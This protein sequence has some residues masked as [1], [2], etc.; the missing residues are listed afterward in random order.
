MSFQTTASQDISGIAVASLL[1]QTASTVSLQ[2]SDLSER[3]QN[4]V[5]KCLPKYQ[6]LCQRY[7]TGASDP[8]LIEILSFSKIESELL[9]QLTSEE[10]LLYN[11]ICEASIA[12]L[13]PNAHHR[14]VQDSQCAEVLRQ[15]PTTVPVPGDGNCGLHAFAYGFVDQ[16][17]A[18][19]AAKLEAEVCKLRRG[20]DEET[21]LSRLS[22]GH[23][24]VD[25]SIFMMALA[26]VLRKIGHQ[27]IPKLYQEQIKE[28]GNSKEVRS[29]MGDLIP[30]DNGK[31]VD[32]EGLIAL[33]RMFGKDVC[34]VREMGDGHHVIVGCKKQPHIVINHRVNHF[35]ARRRIR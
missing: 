17:N 23:Y 35:T 1:K 33:G 16:M 15:F 22:K 19:D 13:Y 10:K 3:V 31:W 7:S 34:V 26:K 29:I 25:D 27:G 18:D 20:S 2:V 4:V 6:E 21:V 32:H 30:Q 9:S 14:A 28:M 8:E 24:S 5:C 12:K 11:R